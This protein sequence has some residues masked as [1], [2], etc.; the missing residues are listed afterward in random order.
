MSKI[1]VAD[2][3]YRI[4]LNSADS[5]RMGV[6]FPSEPGQRK[7]IGFFLVLSMGWAESPPAFCAGTETIADLANA[8][9]ASDM[10]A[11]DVPHRLDVV[12][13]T[14]TTVVS[15][16][17]A[18]SSS[19]PCV[20]V[21]STS[22]HRKLQRPLQYWDVY[23][24]DFLGLVQGNKYRRRRIKRALLHAM[25]KVFRPLDSD[26]NPHRQ[27]P[28]SVKKLLKGDGT[29]DTRKI[30][31]GWI[32]D[33]VNST[34]ELPPHRIARLQEILASVTPKMKVIAVKQW[35][36][37]LG[38]LRSMSIPIPG[39]RGLFSLLQEAFRHVE[40][41][42]PRLRLTKAVHGFLED[43]RWLAN[44]VASRPTRIA[45][46]VPSNP[47]LLGACDAAGT[48]MGGI[49]FI[50]AEDGTLTPILW[51]KPF[52]MSVQSKLVSFTNRG[53]TITNSDLELCGNIA[54]HDVV[55]QFVDIAERTIGTLSDNIANVYWLRKGSTTKTGPAAYL[56]RLQAHHQRFHRYLLLHDYIPGPANEMADICSRAWHLTNSQLLAYFDLHFPQKQRWRLCTL[57]N[58]M[59]TAL[60]SALFNNPS[61]MGLVR[62]MPSQRMHIGKSGIPIVKNSAS[63][64]FSRPITTPSLTLQ[65]LHK[66]MHLERFIPRKS[67][68]QLTTYLTS[69][70][71]LARQTFSR[72]GTPN[73]R[74]SLIDGNIDFR[75]RQQK[76]S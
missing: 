63:T 51:R 11:L 74:L 8:T 9:L 45:E 25:D 6:L 14:S 56:L 65:S 32:I 2:A 13:E 50:P 19:S 36:K 68:S 47:A 27:E 42:R 60:T 64:L 71:L 41:D 69:C 1:D 15:Q 55:A 26:D 61:N 38:E 4:N 40:A 62:R 35:H 58:Q 76:R 30:L 3:F 23:L 43:F 12:S 49:A 37:I 67:L 33:T 52:P 72:V 54:H 57:S 18:S 16:S 48:G 59:N 28:A 73:P 70:A 20:P 46:L 75:L 66:D 24:D 22:S 21:P 7:L 5:I 17:P 53:G 39:A 10:R 44:D 29:W 34:I 31:L